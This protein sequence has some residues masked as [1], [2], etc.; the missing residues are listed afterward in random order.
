M[1]LVHSWAQDFVKMPKPG[2]VR[3]LFD[4][5]GLCVENILLGSEIPE[6]VVVGHVKEAEK[7][8]N[9]D[10]LKVTKV[11]VGSDVRT[12][13]CGAPNVTAGQKVAVAL[14]GT[15][16]PNGM[17][18]E[19]ATI[20][21]VQSNGMI[22]SGKEL[23]LSDDHSGIL[24]LP[25]QAKVGKPAGQFLGSSDVV[26]DIAVFPNRPDCQSVIGLVREVAAA[27]HTTI[28]T[29]RPTHNTQ[30][31]TKTSGKSPVRVTIQKNTDCSFYSAQYLSNVHRC[32]SPDW[33]QKR[34]QLAGLRPID[35]IVDVTNY[36]MLELGQPLHAFDADKLEKQSRKQKAESRNS[37][38]HYSNV[39]IVV[40][41]AKNGEPFQ[42]LD[43]VNRKLGGSMLVITDGNVP[44]ALA[45]VMGGEKSGVGETTTNVILESA[46]FAKQSV[47]DTSHTLKLISE[48]SQR[49]SKG[50]DPALVVPAISRAT[51][52]LIKYAKAQPVG[53]VVSAGKLPAPQKPIR[54]SVRWLNAFLGVTLSRTVIVPILKRLE[55]TVRVTADTLTIQPPTYRHDLAIPEDIAEEVARSINFNSIPR[56]LPKAEAHPVP[57]SAMDA[58][59]RQL[60]QLLAQLG[61]HEHVGYAYVPESFV[62]DKAKAIRIT[63][64]LSKDQEFLRTSLVPG[65]LS[66]AGMNA[67][68]YNQFRLFEFGSVYRKAGKGF[69]ER[70]TLAMLWY[71]HNAIR[72]LKGTL[73]YVINALWPTRCLAFSEVRFRKQTMTLNGSTVGGLLVPAPAEKLR[74]KL[75]QETAVAVLDLW[76]LLAMV[77]DAGKPVFRPIPAFPPV[78]RDIA[79]WVEKSA[80][81][82]TIEAVMRDAD[83]LLIATEL[84][85]LFVQGQRRS[86]A[87]HL[88]FQAPDR[89]LESK[90]VDAIVD[91]IGR[92]LQSAA[93]AQLR[94]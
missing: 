58:T 25:A 40:R 64:P 60:R 31:P 71:K 32:P 87:F 39:H 57:L 55:M 4:A 13:V 78:K 15:V 92:R 82:G 3:E 23:G 90:E 34:L 17:K 5:A 51:A 66:V 43:G 47:Y 54:V 29:Q 21:G 10:K 33:M 1:K 85:D 19:K 28:N 59:V 41:Q 8:P 93:K 91:V 26:Y 83:P 48:S 24:V 35:V 37:E 76:A 45:G 73:T 62:T 38:K 70:F 77:G 16:L 12:I 27:Q 2:R 81:Y 20:R 36:V 61:G 89:T 18:L 75:G 67:K 53:G 42:A 65:L 68:R 80:P 86:L 6:T 88:T 9:A 7:H 44:I 22:C 50:I 56:A 94:R 11:D 63:N 14:P 69:D 46:L 84:F 49:F 79:F 72:E 74:H 52:L 30:Q